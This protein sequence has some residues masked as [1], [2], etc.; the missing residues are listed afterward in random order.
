M[1]SYG[2]LGEKVRIKKKWKISKEATTDYIGYWYE[3]GYSVSSSCK[4]CKDEWLFSRP[5]HR[6]DLQDEHKYDPAV[7]TDSVV[8]GFVWCLLL[9]FFFLKY[10]FL[11]C[12]AKS[13]A[14]L[15]VAGLW[16]TATFRVAQWADLNCVCV[17]IHLA[18][19][20]DRKCMVVVQGTRR[21]V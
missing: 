9:F 4:V 3:S 6:A 13:L 12:E 7:G 11:L 15:Q 20:I 19:H 2:L 21:Q 10:K 18:Y 1:E 16:E 14:L 8:A 5:R 17:I